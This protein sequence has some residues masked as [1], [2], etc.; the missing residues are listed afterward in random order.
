MTTAR[1]SL[2]L[3]RRMSTATSDVLALNADP[4][5]TMIGTAC[6]GVACSPMIASTKAASKR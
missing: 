3:S 4:C 5:W 1:F 2:S 6:E